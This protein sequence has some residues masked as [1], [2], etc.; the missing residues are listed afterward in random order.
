M[1]K[2]HLPRKLAVI[3]HADVV[4]STTLV[5]NNEAL[6]H[7]RIRN[8]FS[9]F[10]E[11]IGSYGGITRE[12]RGDAIL[13]EFH[14]ASD[15]VNAALAFQLS[16]RDLNS[17][18]DDDIRPRLRIGISLGE[19]IVADNTITGAGVVLAQRVE[20]LADPEGLCIT[21][22]LHE[23]LPKNL[24]IVLE[25]LGEQALKGF[26]DLVHVY[27]VSITPGRS[28][29]PPDEIHKPGSFSDK[30]KIVT[31]ALITIMIAIVLAFLF[32]TRE[33]ETETSVVGA[34]AAP[35]EKL[36]IAILPFDNLSN[37]PEQ[38]YFSDGMAEDI[39]T[40]LSQLRDLSVIASNSSFSESS[41]NR[42]RPWC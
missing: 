34:T 40:D 30:W 1:E 36:S 8:A 13:S 41:G 37:D 2:D 3:L 39:I 20:Q 24:P 9:S 35:E 25:D 19:V 7:E 21:A 23:A 29:I 4:G 33:S 12:L 6:A 15:A 38:E 14:R 11:I 16:N 10:S 42:E 31:P 5:Q 32:A 26:D 18:L 17:S 28:I 27:R 22:A